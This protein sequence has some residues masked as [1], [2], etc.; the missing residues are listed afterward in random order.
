MIPVMH[1][2]I[3]AIAL[4]SLGLM[5]VCLRRQWLIMLMGLEIMFSAAGL[6]AIAAG[7]H[8]LNV[9]GQ[10]FTIFLMA[11]TTAELVV[12]LVLVWLAFSLWR[13]QD[14]QDMRYLRDEKS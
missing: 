5:V 14:I 10:I 4:F 12:A 8:W 2:V 1:S 7:Q 3:L 6:L 9:H 13:V 11:V